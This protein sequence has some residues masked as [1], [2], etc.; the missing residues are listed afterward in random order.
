M[1]TD[2]ARRLLPLADQAAPERADAARNRELLLD[3]AAAM[4]AELGADEVT[5]D[6]LAARAGVGKGTVFRRFGSRGG[7]MAALL[8]HTERAWQA[9]VISGPPPLGPGAPPLDRLLALGG[10]RLHTTLQ[11]AAL[12]RAAGAEGRR[13][14]GAHSFA[15]LHVRH[16]LAELGVEGDLPLLAVALLAPLE[17]PVLEQQVRLDGLPV[18]RVLAGWADLVRRVVGRPAVTPPGGAT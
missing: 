14:S 1:T 2:P 10:S 18:E 6:A 13:A 5:M 4:V 9:A 3:A 11:H 7:L 15:A 8:D 16:L 17:V 12:I